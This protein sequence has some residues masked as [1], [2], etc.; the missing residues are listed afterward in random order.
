M[1]N[2][3][4]TIAPAKQDKYLYQI[5]IINIS[6]TKGF[7]LVVTNPSHV[8]FNEKIVIWERCWIVEII[9]IDG[10]PITLLEFMEFLFREF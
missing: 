9:E 8:P 7:V 3:M 5:S 10:G 2:S 1:M 6:K 4:D